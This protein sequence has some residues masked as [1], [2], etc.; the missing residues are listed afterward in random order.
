MSSQTRDFF[1][2]NKSHSKPTTLYTK[3]I[4]ACVRVCVFI[5]SICRAFSDK[6][7]LYI[8]NTPSF[9]FR[10]YGRHHAAVSAS[11]PD[12]KCTTKE[13]YK[14]GATENR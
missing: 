6:T 12:T 7:T 3:Y 4:N 13:A 5:K 10:T 2:I 9:Q 11:I 14:T 8:N 1:H